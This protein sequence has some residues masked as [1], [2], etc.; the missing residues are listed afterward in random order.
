MFLVETNIY[1]SGKKIKYITSCNLL[2]VVRWLKDQK[3][4]T[5]K[6]IPLYHIICGRV[7]IS[8]NENSVMELAT[9]GNASGK[10]NGVNNTNPNDFLKIPILKILTS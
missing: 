8:F 9:F 6:V 5:A 2:I 3:D 1:T 10:R 7:E 4:S